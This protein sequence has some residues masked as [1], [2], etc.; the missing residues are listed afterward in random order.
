[1]IMPDA[2][3]GIKRFFTRAALSPLTLAMLIRFAAAFI[4]HEGR[5]SASQAAGAIRSQ[6]R[7]RAALVRFLADRSWAKDWAVLT[8]VAQLLLRLELRARGT[9]ALLLDQTWCGNRGPRPRIPSA[10][11]TTAAARGRA[12]A[13]TRSWPG[14]PVTDS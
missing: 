4:R 11:A 3:P 8:A 14:A 9:W 5:M 10:G 12:T 6:A 7:H 1:M 13:R 2:L